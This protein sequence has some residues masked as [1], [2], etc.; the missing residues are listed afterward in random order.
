MKLADKIIKLRKKFGWSQEE[1]AERMDVSRQSVSKWEGA[2]SVPD[3]NKIIKL[4]QLFG[5]ST[6]YLLKDNIEEL[7][8]NSSDEPDLKLISVSKA[9]NFIETTYQHSKVVAKGVLLLIASVIPMLFLIGISYSENTPFSSTLAFGVG[10]TLLF[11][12]VASG[13]VVLIGSNYKGRE[14]NK[15]KSIPFE[16]D[17]G[18][19]SILKEEL[20][21]YTPHYFK[22]MA[23]AV[24]AFVLSPVPLIVSAIFNL[25]SMFIMFM[26]VLLISS[27]A[28]GVYFFVPVSAK[29]TAYNQ[30]LKEGEFHPR[31]REKNKHIE[32]FAAFYWPLV[33]AVYIGWSLFT[34]AWGIT[35]IVWPVAGIL[36][37]AFIGLI[38]F[39]K[40]K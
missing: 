32:N 2:L 39:I 10:L 26:V 40:Q 27:V 16:L 3:L 17:Y 23:L 9:R 20:A 13:I 31:E 30:L 36:F 38:Q 11:V 4:G 14:L 33:T 18:V 5:V 29:F 37:A 28:G 1:L 8:I 35:W 15:F 12:M 25:E 21:A 22:A 19:D 7:E 24:P 34:M 6:D